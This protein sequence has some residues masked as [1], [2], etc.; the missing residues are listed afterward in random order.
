MKNYY[1]FPEIFQYILLNDN[2]IKTRKFVNINNKLN[3]CWHY[4]L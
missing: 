2:I 4:D 3:E 1:F